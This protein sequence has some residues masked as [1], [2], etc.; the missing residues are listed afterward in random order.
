MGGEGGFEVGLRRKGGRMDW[1]WVDK[2]ETEKPRFILLE[3]VIINFFSS[4]SLRGCLS[5]FPR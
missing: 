2:G 4:P 5:Y 3:S 1:M